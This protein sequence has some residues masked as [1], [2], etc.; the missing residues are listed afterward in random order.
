MNSIFKRILIC[1]LG[2][3]TIASVVSCN[4]KDA[5]EPAPVYLEV[6]AHNISG[7]WMLKEWNS[8]PLQEGTQMYVKFIRDDK[9]FQMWQTMDSFTDIP[10]YVTGEFNIT[11]DLDHGAVINGKY[12]YDEGLW[13]HRYSVKDLTSDQML[14]VAVDDPQFTQLFVRVDE[15]PFE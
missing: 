2:F 6:N 10:H 13:Q 9:E 8:A 5:T 11:T 14:W 4:E 7:S 15:I 3:G 1:V 12:H